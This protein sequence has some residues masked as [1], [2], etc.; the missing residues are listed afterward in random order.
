MVCKKQFCDLIEH[1]RNSGDKDLI[2]HFQIM[3][4]NAT[5][6]SKILVVELSKFAVNSLK[7]VLIN[8]NKYLSIIWLWLCKK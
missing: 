7:E 6:L 2:R 3:K 4:N 5:Y 8:Q 1:N